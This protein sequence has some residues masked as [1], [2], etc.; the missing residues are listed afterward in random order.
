MM[1]SGANNFKAMAVVQI[2][3][4]IVACSSP[5][6]QVGSMQEAV[7]P[8]KC[9]DGVA[10]KVK[11]SATKY[12]L[13][14]KMFISPVSFSATLKNCSA[15]AVTVSAFDLD[16]I[17]VVSA[18]ANGQ[19]LAFS[20]SPISHLDGLS[21]VIGQEITILKPKEEVVFEMLGLMPET[22]LPNQVPTIST[23]RPSGAGRYEIVF[24]YHYRG[25]D[26]GMSNVFH[27]TV[28]SEIVKF[29]VVE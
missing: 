15:E 1:I 5:D 24:S 10:F 16:N 20:T 19:P 23:Y 2:L 13:Q 4:G 18:L 26:N 29:K 6:A 14:P 22:F 27:G 21:S 12:K 3:T 8:N 17:S 9:P 7:K 28:Q 11:P 25:P